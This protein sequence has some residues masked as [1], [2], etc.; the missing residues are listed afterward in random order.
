M[1][2][3]RRAGRAEV[4]VR[5]QLDPPRVARVR[6]ERAERAAEARVAARVRLA[7]LGREQHDV[8][9]AGDGSRE[10]RVDVLRERAGVRDGVVRG[11]R[12]QRRGMAGIGLEVRA[13]RAH[14]R[15]AGDVIAQVHLLHGP[16]HGLRAAKQAE[17]AASHDIFR[18]GAV[19]GRGEVGCH[20]AACLP[21]G[22]RRVTGYHRGVIRELA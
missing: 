21:I 14:R 2:P 8:P 10:E 18:R 12:A 5:K 1:L 19:R 11:V 15:A 13:S 17:P 9:R 20:V 3:D 4:L 7:Q 16:A 22:V 6:G